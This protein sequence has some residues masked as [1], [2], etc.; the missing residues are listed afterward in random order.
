MSTA[1]A[2]MM[3]QCVYNGSLSVHDTDIERRPYHRN[4]SC[5]LHKSKGACPT[6]CLQ[7]GNFSFTKKQKWNDCS[8]SKTSS[9][10]P[11]QPSYRGDSSDKNQEPS[12]SYK[13]PKQATPLS[14]CEAAAPY[15]FDS[16]S[17]SLLAPELNAAPE[18]RSALKVARSINM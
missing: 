1:A 6:A 2:E 13:T 8:L 7:H 16:G 11:S 4:C 10:I 18:L 17:L 5:A 14:T 3:L 12:E 15:P 9:R